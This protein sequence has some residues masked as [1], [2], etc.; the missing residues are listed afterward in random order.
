MPSGHPWPNHHDEQSGLY[1]EAGEEQGQDEVRVIGPPGS[2]NTATDTGSRGSTL[3]TQGAP[4]PQVIPEGAGPVNP[5]SLWL[6]FLL[7]VLRLL[8]GA[9]R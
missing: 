6:I 7:A 5:R 4:E 1:E 3:A 9:S 8:V 2:N